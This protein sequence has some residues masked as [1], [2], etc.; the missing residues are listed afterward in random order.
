MNRVELQ[1]LAEER[2]LDAQALVSAARW[3][4]AYYL[5]GYAV[6]CAVKACIAKMTNLHDYPDKDFVNQCYTHKI[7]RLVVL[8]GLES[9]LTAD[10]TADPLLGKNWQIAKGWDEKA[11]YQQWTEP[12]AR[13]LF[14]AVSETNHG[15]L[16]WIRVHW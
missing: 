11:R 10:A 15:V 6:E 13:E 5:T 1:Q 8:S 12:Q 4:G 9:Q 3:S 16:P 7:D 14:E 2:L